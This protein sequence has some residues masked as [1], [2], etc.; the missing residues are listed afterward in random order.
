MVLICRSSLG[1]VQVRTSSASEPVLTRVAALCQ[2]AAV[3]AGVVP[4]AQAVDLGF[5]QH[6]DSAVTI[7]GFLPAPACVGPQPGVQLTTLQLCPCAAFSR[8]YSSAAIR[9]FT[10]CITAVRWLPA[11]LRPS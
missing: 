5:L 3:P 7:A 2:A 4:G 9:V 11:P 10:F 6:Q 1:C 8:L